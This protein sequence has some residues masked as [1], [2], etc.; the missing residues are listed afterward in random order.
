MSMPNTM[1]KI[2]MATFRTVMTPVTVALVLAP[3]ATTMVTTPRM[4][5]APSEMSSQGMEAKGL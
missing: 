4:A 1:T 2:T 3:P 5:G